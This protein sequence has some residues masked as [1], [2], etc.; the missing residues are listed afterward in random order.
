MKSTSKFR[1]LILINNE[2][3]P[4]SNE[5]LIGRCFF[6][7]NSAVRVINVCRLKTTHVTVEREID[8]KSWSVSAGLIRRVIGPKKKKRTA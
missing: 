6:D 8:G 1:Q 5:D 7:G 4:V 2:P 3:A